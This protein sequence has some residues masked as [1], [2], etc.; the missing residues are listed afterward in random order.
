MV[1]RSRLQS[2]PS[3]RRRICRADR[4]AGLVLPVPHLVDEQLAAEVLLGLAVRRRAASPPRSG[5]RCPRG[6]CRAA[7][8]PRSPACACA[9]SGRPSACGRAR[10]PCA[11]CPS[12]SAA[13]AR[14]STGGLPLVGVGREVARVDPALIQLGL[15]R[16][17]SHDFGRD[18]T[19]GLSA[20]FGL[21]V[22][23]QSRNCVSAG[24]RGGLRLPTQQPAQD[25]RRARRPSRRRA[26]CP[27]MLPSGLFPPPPPRRTAED[28]A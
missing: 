10:G 27:R 9:G 3:P 19:P 18:S 11:G 21:T 5:W 20:D 26:R 1:K 12:R 7:T 6:P 25:V 17:G 16:A 24:R 15:Y 14:S 4:S 8:A 2:T 23:R 22:T 28:A 13:A